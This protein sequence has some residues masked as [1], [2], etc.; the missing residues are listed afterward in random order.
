MT[1]GKIAAQCAHA[2]QKL[3]LK[4]NEVNCN[5]ELKNS[6]RAWISSS[7]KKVK[8]IATDIEFDI[9]RVQYPD[10]FVI[11]DGDNPSVLGLM[12]MKKSYASEAIINIE[13]R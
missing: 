13:K 7:F 6:Y 11:M 9:I 2:T 1:E 8:L 10:A 12:P 4:G 5:Y 3:I